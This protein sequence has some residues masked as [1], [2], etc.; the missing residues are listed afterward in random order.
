MITELERIDYE[1]KKNAENGIK[2]SEFI[3][4]EK[5][6]FEQST[7]YKEMKIG[8]KYFAN[9]SDNLIPFSAFFFNS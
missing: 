2:L 5:K 1:L 4:R 7:R 9:S 3:Y 8:D 6:E